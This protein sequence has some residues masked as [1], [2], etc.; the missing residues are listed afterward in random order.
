M[1]TRHRVVLIAAALAVA[2][3]FARRPA[4]TSDTVVHEWGTFTSVSGE[5]GRAVSWFPLDGPVDLPCFVG[6]SYP[7]SPKG[8]MFARVRMETPVLY[9]YTS[10]DATVADFPRRAKAVRR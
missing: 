9:F 2:T 7:L 5:D 3:G 1:L 4:I 8:A 10:R 6:R